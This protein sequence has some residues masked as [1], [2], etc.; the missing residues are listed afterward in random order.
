MNVKTERGF[1]A[2]EYARLD[3]ATAAHATGPTFAL[4]DATDHAHRL[5]LPVAELS[6]ENTID[7]AD[8]DR[9]VCAARDIIPEQLPSERGYYR[10]PFSTYR[11]KDAVL[12]AAHY[13]LILH[14]AT[15]DGPITGL[16]LA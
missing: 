5:A 10:I 9:I 14:R 3:A 13:S 12:T 15:T 2:A 16:I 4:A 8:L 7:A 11:I 6:I 1:W